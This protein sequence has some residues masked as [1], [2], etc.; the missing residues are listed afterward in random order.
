MF[1]F[2]GQ[3]QSVPGSCDSV[4]AEG[5]GDQVHKHAAEERRQ[6]CRFTLIAQNFVQTMETKGFLQ[7]EIII[8]YQALFDSFEYLCYGSTVNDKEI[9]LTLTVRGL[10]V[11]VKF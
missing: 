3:L 11:D 10:T 9:F 7:F 1:A 5:D 8:A 6:V 2:W 4:K